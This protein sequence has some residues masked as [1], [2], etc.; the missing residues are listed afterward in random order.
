[1]VKRELAC[2]LIAEKKKLI[3]TDKEYEEKIAEYAER[4]NFDDVEQFKEQ[5]GEDFIKTAILQE[6]VVDYLVDKCVQ[7]EETGTTETK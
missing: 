1:M 4:S 5:Y 6:K 2:N 3:P 7:V